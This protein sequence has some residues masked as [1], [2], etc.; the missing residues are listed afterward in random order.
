MSILQ[1]YADRN[2]YDRHMD[3]FAGKLEAGRI[4]ASFLLPWDCYGSECGT[5]EQKVIAFKYRG[6][7]YDLH[8]TSDGRLIVHQCPPPVEDVYPDD[9]NV[10][11]G[12]GNIRDGGW[13]DPGTEPDSFADDPYNYPDIPYVDPTR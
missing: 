12:D 5:C 10:R 8:E 4:K 7:R 2:W 6:T 11:D 1:K 9:P 3:D 13:S